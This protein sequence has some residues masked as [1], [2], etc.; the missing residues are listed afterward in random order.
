MRWL[1]GSKKDKN[2]SREEVKQ[3]TPVMES[4]FDIDIMPTPN[5]NALKFVVSSPLKIKE[6]LLTCAKKSV[7]KMNWRNIFLKSEELITFTYL[8]T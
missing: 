6:V 3:E 5:P 8:I 2:S 7:V 1:W 4:T